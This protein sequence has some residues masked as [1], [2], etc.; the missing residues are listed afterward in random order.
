MILDEPEAR[1]ALLENSTS[2][3]VVGASENPSRPSY[4]VFAYLRAHGY[5]VTPV[6]P[7]LESV[8]GVRAY[9][10][11]VAMAADHGAPDLVDVF[12]KA[13]DALAVV[14]DAIAAHA[15]AVWFQ[16]G[17]INPEA[18]A[19]ADAAGLDV[20]VDFCTKIEHRALCR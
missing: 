9:P 2:I 8:D 6:N 20:V 10:S 11:L 18:I 16:L 17:I 1:R 13:D 12:R 4:G 15:K 14:D 3:A 5:Q 7:N 19:R